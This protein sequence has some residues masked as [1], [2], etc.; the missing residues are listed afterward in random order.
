MHLFHSHRIHHSQN[1]TNIHNL[2]NNPICTKIETYYKEP[3]LISLNPK[4]P[5]MSGVIITTIIDKK[6]KSVKLI[7]NHPGYDMKYIESYIY[8]YCGIMIINNTL[9]I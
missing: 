4:S 7:N 6:V 3:N 1:M 9:M 5:I 8:N 2:S